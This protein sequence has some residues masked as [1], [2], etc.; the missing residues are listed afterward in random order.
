[1][2]ATAESLLSCLYPASRAAS[3]TRKLFAV[4]FV[5]NAK[6]THWYQYAPY[7]CRPNL[8]TLTLCFLLGGSYYS[9]KSKIYFIPAESKI[10]IFTPEG[11][12]EHP[13]LFPVREFSYFSTL[14]FLFR[15]VEGLFLHFNH[16]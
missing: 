12:D 10:S 7:F 16:L 8:F 4:S 13:I 6:V 9:Q 11:D 3:I 1:M 15:I 14:Y 2:R 5:R